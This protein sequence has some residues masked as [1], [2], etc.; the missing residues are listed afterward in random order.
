VTE[1]QWFRDFREKADRETSSQT[2]KSSNADVMLKS[3]RDVWEVW[4]RLVQS[5]GS[6]SQSSREEYE[7]KGIDRIEL[8]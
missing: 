8:I 6:W 3:G 4:S 1:E 2:S 7:G 5:N